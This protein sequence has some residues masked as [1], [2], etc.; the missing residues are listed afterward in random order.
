MH[1]SRGVAE[2]TAGETENRGAHAKPRTTCSSSWPPL[3]YPVGVTGEGP[4]P[5]MLGFGV[6]T[7]TTPSQ[8]ARMDVRGWSDAP[9][10]TSHLSYYLK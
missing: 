5:G 4:G 7:N 9:N 3:K 8:G 10:L 2:S 1:H 6:Q